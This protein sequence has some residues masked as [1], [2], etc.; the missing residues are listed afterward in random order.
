MPNQLPSGAWRARVRNPRTGKQINPAA[1]IGG[2]DTFSTRAQAL[3]AENEARELLRSQARLGVTVREFW[4]E[5][6]TDPL[7][8]RPSP[9]TMIHYREATQA[10]VERYGDLAMRA[11]GDLH[12]ADWLRREGTR[13]SVKRLATMWNDAAS[14]AAGRL[15]ERNPWQ[16]LRLP[17]QPKKDRTPPGIEKIAAMIELADE[18]TPPSFAAYLEFS[19]HMGTRPGEADALRWTKID[20]QAATV[21]ID[22]QWNVKQRAFTEPKH[23][24]IRTIALTDPAAQRLLSLPDESE[25]AFTTLTGSHYTPSTRQWHWNR[26]R[27]AAGL[28]NVDFYACTRHYFGWYAWNVLELD[29]RDISLH[30]GHRDGGRLVQTTYGHADENLARRRVRAAY[31]SA[32]PA[33][34]PFRRTGE[35]ARE[36]S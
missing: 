26:V 3:A 24:L 19:C 33:P 11:V 12:V 10:F 21:R 18:L 17:R 20:F 16:G 1:I 30:L 5:W 35:A 14:A 13:G 28:G 32:P 31:A 4:N 6:T 15:V 22:E 25:F 7:W 27:C 36:Q 34:I 29:A 8:A 2:P 9:S 23:H